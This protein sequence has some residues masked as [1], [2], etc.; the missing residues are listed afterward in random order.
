MKINVT[1]D[2]S[3]ASAPPGF[4]AAVNYVVG[5]FDST[6][7]NPVT[8][9]VDVGWGEVDGQKL[10]AGNLGES[11]EQF[12]QGYG[13][14]QILNAFNA[15]T[16]QA[17]DPIPADVLPVVDPT[18]AGTL[19]PG[20]AGAR[21][22]G[23]TPA[24]SNMIDG[25]I[26]LSSIPGTFSFDLSNPPS[27]D[28][29]DAV[30]VIEHELTEIMGRGAGLNPAYYSMQDLFR[31]SAPG[32]LD[33]TGNHSDYFSID[34]GVTALDAFNSSPSNGDLGDW[35]PSA[36]NDAM[37]AIASPGVT[38]SMTTID[39][40]EMAAIGWSD[41]PA[42]LSSAFTDVM[43][44]SPT[45]TLAMQPTL[46]L[47]DGS[48]VPNPVY[49]D[50]NAL[51]GLSG[52]VSAN[53][54]TIEQALT[55]VEQFAA[56]TTTVSSLTYEFFTGATP[57]AAGYQYLIDSPTNPNNLDSPYYAKFN[58]E[59][60]YINFSVNLGKF[61]AGAT[62]FNDTYGALSLSDAATKAYT[63]IFGAAPVAGKIDAILNTE[64]TFGGVTETRADYF[65]HYG[66]DGLTGIGTKAAMV[67]WLLEVA[68][69]G[70]LGPYAGAGD[71]FISDLALGNAPFNVDLLPQ[72]GYTHQV[73]LV[74]V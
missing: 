67:G 18:G 42:I 15:V 7:T 9:N 48:S 56:A 58:I 8:I 21:A 19:D 68:V 22:L 23:L 45:S 62:P 63:E 25:W 26:G 74:G 39:L 38:E 52:Q 61:G 31:F 57:T 41:I 11:I 14:N 6:F 30:A 4:E 66:G 20:S 73:P 53:N 27:G 46:T 69:Q 51:P 36:G 65:A 10:G 44:T 35:A 43:W 12:S 40:I 17:G 49:Q 29:F 2:P 5:L 55:T 1:F 60:R 13:Y 64:V 24:T 3:A 16:R 50:A 33:L 28:L 72:Y 32:M 34:K 47:A 59:N 54:T 71:H 37:L 70:D